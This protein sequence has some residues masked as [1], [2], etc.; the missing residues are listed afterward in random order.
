MLGEGNIIAQAYNYA[1]KVAVWDDRREQ[2]PLNYCNVYHKKLQ[3]EK[4]QLEKTN[5]N[6]HYCVI[7]FLLSG[8]ED[9]ELYPKLT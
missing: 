9:I 8:T 4:L 7:I 5:K 2:A 3:R 6:N 1:H